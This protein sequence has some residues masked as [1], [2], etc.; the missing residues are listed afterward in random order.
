MIGNSGKIGYF[1]YSIPYVKADATG[2]PTK[3]ISYR[4]LGKGARGQ[5]EKKNII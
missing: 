3:K 1:I 4:F 2:L 5:G